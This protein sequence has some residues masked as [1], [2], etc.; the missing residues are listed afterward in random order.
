MKKEYG[1]IGRYGISTL[2]SGH[3]SLSQ[4]QKTG[5]E[6][7]S[8]FYG[9]PK[10]HIKIIPH[11]TPDF[12][13]NGNENNK[14]DYDPKKFGIK[15]KY[16]IYPAQFWSHKNHANI[17]YALKI[18]K[19]KYRIPLSIIFTG[20][21]KGNFSHIQ[22]MTI[23]LQLSEDVLF[24]GFISRADLISLYQNAFALL[25]PTFF[26]PEN[27]PPLEAFALGCPVIASKISG[28]DEQ[29][30]DAALLVDPKSPEQI[31]NAIFTL[32][33]S[34][35]LRKTLIERGLKR[36]QQWTGKDFVRSLFSILD[37][38]EAIRRCWE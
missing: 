19:E 12:A 25:Y 21:D 20:S 8:S 11:P 14:A 23:D 3:H 34:P 4:E 32:Y 18:I 28:A 7:I 30:G 10:E 15:T 38:F 17:L 6:E 1:T 22:K 37:D 24:L 36:A 27:L 16:L 2:Y 33:S 35:D 5:Q 9:I 13:L 26:G 31:A 29:L